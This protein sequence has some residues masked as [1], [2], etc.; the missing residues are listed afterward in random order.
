MSEHQLDDPLLRVAR[1]GLHEPERIFPDEDAAVMLASRI[2]AERLTGIANFALSAGALTVSPDLRH[3]LATRHKKAQ[4]ACLKLERKLIEVSVALDDRGINHIVLKGPVLARSVYPSPEWRSFVDIDLLVR[5]ADWVRAANTLTDLGFVRRL[6]EPRKGFTEAFAKAAAFK[7]P[8]GIEV[9]LH[10]TLAA[11]PFGLW[12]EADELFDHAQWIQIGGHWLKRLSDT[13]L[14]LHGCV[15]ASLG[16]QPPEIQPLRD[17]AQI[18]VNGAIDWELLAA[19][20]TRWK[21][22]PVFAHSFGTVSSTLG[23]ELPGD[24][25]SFQVIRTSKKEN[26]VLA[27]YTTERR[28][29]G[30][31]EFAT[32]RAIPGIRAKASYASA[33]IFPSHEF[34]QRRTPARNARAKRLTVPLRN[35]LLRSSNS[36]GGSHKR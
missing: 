10:R 18:A 22:A 31:T 9:D 27:A 35:Y 2:V 3:R 4:L 11:G 1:F 34:L 36:R 8:S 21:L 20:G 5:S 7:H 12:M 24:S 14:L 29:R 17:V 25:A 28:H 19:W 15:H 30:A 32:L 26:R 13:A 6:P 16:W 33:L 23:I